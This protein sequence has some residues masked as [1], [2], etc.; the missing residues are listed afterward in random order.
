MYGVVRRD[1]R[2]APMHKFP[3]VVYYQDRGS[4]ALIIAVQRGRRSV[5]A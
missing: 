4:Y 3:Y 2:A 5:R 1:I